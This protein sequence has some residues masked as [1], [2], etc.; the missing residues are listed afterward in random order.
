MTREDRLSGVGDQP[1]AA[2]TKQRERIRNR[3]QLLGCR[4]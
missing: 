2:L 1:G 4:F 3:C